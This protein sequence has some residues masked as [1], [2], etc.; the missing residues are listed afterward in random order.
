VF[1]HEGQLTNL[2]IF[3]RRPRDSRSSVWVNYADAPYLGLE[4]THFL[5]AE[6]R[7]LR[8]NKG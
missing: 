2:I 1:F 4:F 5:S 8:I 7:R 6:M 3:T